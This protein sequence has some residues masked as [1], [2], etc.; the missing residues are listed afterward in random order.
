M[1]YSDKFGSTRIID[2]QFDNLVINWDYEDDHLD[3]TQRHPVF[4]YTPDMED[5]DK[6]GCPEHF[7]I[8]LTRDQAGTLHKWLADYLEDTK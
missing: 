5:K 6:H 8:R 3:K 1:G 7:H 4:L 2:E